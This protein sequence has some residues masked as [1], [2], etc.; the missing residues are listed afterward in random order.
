MRRIPPL[1]NRA[2]EHIME[3][4]A[5]LRP[6]ATLTLALISALLPALPVTCT[7]AALPAN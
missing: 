1:G 2:A 3:I 7:R 6:G 5:Q 4:G